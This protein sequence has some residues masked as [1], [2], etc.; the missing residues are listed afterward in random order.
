[1]ELHDAELMPLFQEAKQT[2][3]ANA[4]PEL[5]SEH[6][7]AAAANGSAGPRA[8]LRRAMRRCNLDPARLR[9]Q[10]HC[11][12][13]RTEAQADSRTLPIAPEVV[14]ALIA[15]Q[16][17]RHPQRLACLL[18]HL[19]R[20]GDRGHFEKH[21]L[22]P[23][24]RLPFAGV[25]DLVARLQQHQELSALAI[26]AT[27]KAGPPGE[28]AVRAALE[29]RAALAFAFQATPKSRPLRR[30]YTACDAVPGTPS[31]AAL[32]SLILLATQPG[33]A[34][35]SVV[36]RD[37]IARQGL[38]GTHAI[39]AGVLEGVAFCC[40]S[41]FAR[42]LCPGN[43]PSLIDSLVPTESLAL[44]LAEAAKQD[45]ISRSDILRAQAVLEGL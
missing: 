30:V 19:L 5:R 8:A 37:L 32:D 45:P 1:M 16:G 33:S 31:A 9:K 13:K 41:G 28:Q 15:L 18:E 20:E 12:S 21:L 26:S 43:E 10:R 6:L 14:S 36:V 11:D 44:L 2:A 40:Q 23:R 25:A 34:S 29:Q 35:N 3:V 38:L 39:V 4:C 24:D 42:R 27:R 7:L 17:S 22:V